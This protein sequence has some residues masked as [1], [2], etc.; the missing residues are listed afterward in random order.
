VNKKLKVNNN[1]SFAKRVTIPMV[2]VWSI[3]F[4][5]FLIAKS[6]SNDSLNSFIIIGLI[7]FILCSIVMIAF[8]IFFKSYDKGFEIFGIISI[9]LFIITFFAVEDNFINIGYSVVF[10]LAVTLLN[11]FLEYVYGKKI[12]DKLEILPI[13]II[14]M[15]ITMNLI[16]CLWCIIPHYNHQTKFFLIL[17]LIYAIFKIANIINKDKK[18]YINKDI[19]NIY[20]YFSVTILLL[21]VIPY[22]FISLI[23]MQVI[24]DILLFVKNTII[25]MLLHFHPSIK[26]AINEICKMINMESAMMFLSVLLYA[27][28]NAL[29]VVEVFDFYFG[30][31]VEKRNCM[32]RLNLLMYYSFN[33]I[34]ISMVAIFN[35]EL[36]YKKVFGISINE[37]NNYFITALSI[38][39]TG[40]T[41]LGLRN[42]KDNNT[43]KII[44][45]MKKSIDKVCEKNRSLNKKFSKCKYVIRKMFR[46][47]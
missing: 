10:I 2:V 37:N 23:R 4:M 9:V 8:N 18:L 27:I 30:Y 21:F 28:F 19:A 6:Y 40:I 33:I 13:F 25:S 43:E 17:P 39:M 15:I 11:V 3:F 35:N 45:D 7:T 31:S 29:I 46:I 16:L 5:I 20:I 38:V 24:Y 32:C 36:L 41:F 22:F 12:F 14:P 26:N 1:K 47:H 44:M 34:W 42:E